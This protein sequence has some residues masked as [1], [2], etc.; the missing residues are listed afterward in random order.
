M[1]VLRLLFF[2]PS[3]LQ[4]LILP[5]FKED[6]TDYTMSKKLEQPGLLLS[7]E[8]AKMIDPHTYWYLDFD[9]HH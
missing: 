6:L 2:L 9:A 4:N 8:F 5:L 7:S 1:V 3:P